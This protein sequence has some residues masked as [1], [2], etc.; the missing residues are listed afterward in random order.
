MGGT[1]GSDAPDAAADIRLFTAEEEGAEAEAEAEEEG[2]AGGT[3][4]ASAPPRPMEPLDTEGR[5]A[6]LA[7]TTD[8]RGE[9][10]LDSVAAPLPL[11][12]GVAPMPAKDD[13][14]PRTP[15]V[16]GV[17]ELGLELG[18]ASLERCGERVM[19]DRRT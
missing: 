5:I 10:F 8:G 14:Q 4:E 11:L 9:A 1:G 15:P 2:G 6:A 19:I 17:L 7:L 16:G 13:S 12:S 3:T 18:P